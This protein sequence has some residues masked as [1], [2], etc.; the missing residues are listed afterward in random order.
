MEFN[1]KQF[2]QKFGSYHIHLKFHILKP[3]KGK[4]KIRSPEEKKGLK[5]VHKA[6]SKQ[7]STKI[8]ALA[9]HFSYCE[10]PFFFFSFFLFLVF[11]FLLCSLFL[12]YFHSLMNLSWLAE[13]TKPDAVDTAK[14][15]T[16][17]SW[18]DRVI[19]LFSVV[20]QSSNDCSS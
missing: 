14:D 2:C 3:K 11:F 1:Y 16:K 17:P 18:A 12:F 19:V 5:T 15:D 20:F 10:L 4:R 13:A 7:T 8:T 6:T 9:F